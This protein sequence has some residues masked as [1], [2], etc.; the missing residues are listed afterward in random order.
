MSPRILGLVANVAEEGFTLLA[1]QQVLAASLPV[2]SSTV[3]DRT[4]N[5]E[6]DVHIWVFLHTNIPFNHFK[7]DFYRLYLALITPVICI[8][9]EMLK[10]FGLL[11]ANP[12]EPLPALSALQLAASTLFHG[13]RSSAFL[14]WARLGALFEVNSIESFLHEFVLFSDLMHLVLVLDK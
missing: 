12:A 7:R 8:L 11:K 1:W 9:F 5:T 3:W 10:T 2:N 13:N 4:P 6:F 14:V